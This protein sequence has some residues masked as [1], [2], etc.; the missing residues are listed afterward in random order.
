VCF[1]TLSIATW[2]CSRERRH[3]PALLVSGFGF[4]LLGASVGILYAYTSIAKMDAQWIAGNTIRRISSA[5]RVFAPI[6]DVAADFGISNERFW[7][8]LSISVIPLELTVALA[9]LIAVI[10]DSSR[11]RWPRIATSCAFWLALS[12]HVG[13]EAMGLEIGWFSY[14]MLALA[15]AYLLP[16]P[17]I[18][19]LALFLTWPSRL[20]ANLLEEQ[21]AK[22]RRPSE[23][24]I[25]IGGGA[26]VLFA[27]AYL[28]DLPGAFGAASV[29]VVGLIGCGIAAAIS[30]ELGYAR[31][32]AIASGFAAALMWT[33]IGASSVRW[34][35][36]RYLGGDFSRRGQNE[37]ALEAF[38]RGE[39]YAPKGENRRSKIEA[40][41]RAL[42]R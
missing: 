32:L 30:G 10:Q 17:A 24:L 39:R 19:T 4:N 11:S 22:A 18:E 15:C 9:Y 20:L 7:S 33:A 26:I 37:A 5:G 14:Y 13:A 34:D 23:L 1:A 8:M 27:V 2:F 41:R 38:E 25:A 40:L 31:R 36:Y 16:G 6:A 29:A 21:S 35:F 12:L 3:E 42:G 28:I